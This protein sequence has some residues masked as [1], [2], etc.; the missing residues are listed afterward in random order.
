MTNRVVVAGIGNEYRSDDGAGPAVANYVASR[1]PG[2]VE[3]RVVSEPLDLLGTWD[4][5]D[6]AVVVDAT[7]SGSEPG[8]V[9]VVDLG[10]GEDTGAYLGTV[11]THG[12]DLARVLRLARA[13]GRAPVRVVVVGVEGANFEDG[14]DLSAAVNG[15][16]REA[17]DLVLELV[18]STP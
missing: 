5:A 16:V 7:R 15:A 6:L 3:S 18:G 1:A 10:D 9:Q 13:I 11:S 12:L 4:E 8:T 17:G 14:P 2:V